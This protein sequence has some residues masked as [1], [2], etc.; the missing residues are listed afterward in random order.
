MRESLKCPSC[1]SEGRR[2]KVFVGMQTRTLMAVHTYY[3]E[4]GRLCVDDPNKTTSSY[5]CSNGHRWT[6]KT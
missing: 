2:S 1:V 6:E 4:D 3:D 5:S